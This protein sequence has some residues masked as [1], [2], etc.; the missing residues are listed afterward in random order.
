MKN[1]IL[2]HFLSKNHE[3]PCWILTKPP[4]TVTTSIYSSC[5]ANPL[6]IQQKSLARVAQMITNHYRKGREQP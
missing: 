4:P 3:A 1:K 6:L 2:K 5:P